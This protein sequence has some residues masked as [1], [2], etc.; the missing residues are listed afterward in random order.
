[1]FGKLY[2]DRTS[3]PELDRHL[4]ENI[5]RAHAEAA[6]ALAASFGGRGR[7]AERTGALIRL[8]LDFWTWQRLSR[9][10]FD[11]EAAADLMAGAAAGV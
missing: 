2:S 8:A 1:M 3:V 5:D 9:E 4:E 10:G 7:R 11:D 6:S